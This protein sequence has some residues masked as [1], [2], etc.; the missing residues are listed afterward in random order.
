MKQKRYTHKAAITKGELGQ[1]SKI[2]EEFEE[3]CDAHEQGTAMFEIIEMADLL[4]AILHYIWNR[5][6]M[7]SPMLYVLCLARGAWKTIA[8]AACKLR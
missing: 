4:G 1:F 8:R 5:Y 3:L 6:L 2:R 7:L